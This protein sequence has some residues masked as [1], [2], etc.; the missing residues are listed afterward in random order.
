MELWVYLNQFLFIAQWVVL[1]AALII[2]LVMLLTASSYWRMAGALVTAASSLSIAFLFFTPERL[3]LTSYLRSL[4][5]P[6]GPA[7]TATPTQRTL[8]VHRVHDLGG[9]NGSLSDALTLAE[10]GLFDVLLAKDN[11]AGARIVGRVDLVEADDCLERRLNPEAKI[12][13]LMFTARTG[14]R[15]CGR[16]TPVDLDMPADRLDLWTYAP[17]G[18]PPSQGADRGDLRGVMALSL[19]ERG[20]TRELAVWKKRDRAEGSRNGKFHYEGREPHSMISSYLSYDPDPVA[21]V[22]SVFGKNQ[23]TLPSTGIVPPHE[24]VENAGAILERA[25][26]RAASVPGPK[27]ELTLRAALALIGAPPRNSPEVGQL[28]TL[29]SRHLSEGMLQVRVPSDCPVAHAAFDFRQSLA[30]FCKVTDASSSGFRF[31]GVPIDP[32]TYKERC[33]GGFRDAIWQDG[34]TKG[35]RTLLVQK[36]SGRATTLAIGSQAR[37]ATLHH[38]DVGSEDGLIDLV[39]VSDQAIWSFAGATECIGRITVLGKSSGLVG[40]PADRVAFRYRQGVERAGVYLKPLD[41]DVLRT[42]LARAPETIVRTRHDVTSIGKEAGVGSASAGCRTE[43]GTVPERAT[44]QNAAG[45]SI[46]AA[47]AWPTQSIRAED[48]IADPTDI[49]REAPRQ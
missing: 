44:T 39:I 42:M 25:D 21:L 3:A 26:A 2:G 35:R 14:F 19:T 49:V 7:V 36:E 10:T 12:G 17:P 22:L 45:K 46:A 1:V 32:E 37:R 33:L 6:A 38:V 5:A 41:L 31:C 11:H 15:R 9:Q 27:R 43:P 16:V 4:K 13:A 20:Q 8:V 18:K 47:E 23:E 48:V 24:L 29:A 28:M 30:P 40:I 34:T